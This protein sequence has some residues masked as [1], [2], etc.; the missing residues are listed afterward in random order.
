MWVKSRYGLEI[1]SEAHRQVKDWPAS[2]YEENQRD[3]DLVVFGDSPANIGD[4]RRA[5]R[6]GRRAVERE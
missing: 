2:L 5:G 1:P 4:L 3:L 6:T